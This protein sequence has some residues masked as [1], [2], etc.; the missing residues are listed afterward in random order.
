MTSTLCATENDTLSLHKITDVTRYGSLKKLLMLTGYVIRFAQSYYAKSKMKCLLSTKYSRERNIREGQDELRKEKKFKSL[1]AS[2][3]LFEQN[4]CC[5]TE[6][7]I[8]EYRDE[9]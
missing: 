4:G 3:K 8:W 1:Y 5:K 9:T 6:G 7:T 2:L